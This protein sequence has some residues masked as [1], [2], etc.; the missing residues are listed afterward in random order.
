MERPLSAVELRGVTK[1]FGNAVA[2]DALSLAARE[3]EFLTLLGPSGWNSRT[4]A[5]ST[6]AARR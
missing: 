4:W 6:W 2:L 5:A 3:G 1:R